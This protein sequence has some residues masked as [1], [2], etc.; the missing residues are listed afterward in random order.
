MCSICSATRPRNL[1]LTAYDMRRRVD[2]REDIVDERSRE[3]CSNVL[4]RDMEVG[5]H[6]HPVNIYHPISAVPPRFL[7]LIGRQLPLRVWNFQKS[8]HIF[9]R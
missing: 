1:Y 9:L 2:V 3:G 4:G 7:D 8:R 5:L 6:L